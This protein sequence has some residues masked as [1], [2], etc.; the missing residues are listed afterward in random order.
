[1]FRDDVTISEI[2]DNQKSKNYTSEDIRG[3]EELPKQWYIFIPIIGPFLLSRWL[4]KHVHENNMV[5]LKRVVSANPRRNW[6]V[7]S[8]CNFFSKCSLVF[9]SIDLLLGIFLGLQ[10]YFGINEF[11]LGPISLWSITVIIM[12]AIYAVELFM[13]WRVPAVIMKNINEIRIRTKR[14]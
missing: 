4:K 3:L 8:F 10:F 14:I 9:D 12:V 5:F 11:S 1:M 2:I 13:T 7:K 6:T